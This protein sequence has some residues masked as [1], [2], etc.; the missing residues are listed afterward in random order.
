MV[1]RQRRRSAA[2][3]A[4]LF[5]TIDHAQVKKPKSGSK[6][7]AAVAQPKVTQIDIEGLRAAIKPKGKPLL[8]NFWATWCD[9]CRD[10]FPDLVKIDAAY[11]DRIDFI[12]VS[13]DDLI[14]IRRAVPKFLRANKAWMPAY[15]LKTPD[16]D[17]AIT[18]VTPDWA[19]NLP[20]TILIK[21]TGGTAYMRNG[22]I[23][24]EAVS[25]EIDKL[26]SAPKTPQQ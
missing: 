22:K 25:A 11:R 14:E 8:I 7:L 9:P 12:T 10:E 18:M 3:F 20:L 6:K 16:E 26:L 1:S 23:T 19:G 5:V 13:L 24:I 21:E 4:F 15:L 17:A 2:V